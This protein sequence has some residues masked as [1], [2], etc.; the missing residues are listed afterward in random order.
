MRPI[1]VFKKPG[2]AIVPVGAA[3]IKLNIALQQPT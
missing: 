3:Q 1:G 2:E